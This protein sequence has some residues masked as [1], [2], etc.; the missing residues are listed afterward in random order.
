MLSTVQIIALL[1]LA[2]AVIYFILPDGAGSKGKHGLAMLKAGEAA[3]RYGA[4]VIIEERLGQS[5]ARRFL[6][7]FSEGLAEAAPAQPGPATPTPPPPP[8]P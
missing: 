2:G 7:S 3:G 6:R 8:K 1:V 5:E 4:A